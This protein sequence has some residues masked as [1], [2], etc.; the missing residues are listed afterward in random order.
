M[1]ERDV[2]DNALLIADPA[3][4]R[5]YIATVCGS[6]EAL[7]RRVEI[8]VHAHDGA[9]L[10]LEQPIFP[11]PEHVDPTRAGGAMTEQMK[12]SGAWPDGV[13]DEDEEDALDFLEP[14][15]KPGSL[16]RLSHYEVLEIL[17][18]GGFGTVVKAFDE[19]LHRMVA[20]KIMARG[21]AA[22]SPARKRFLREARAAAAIRHENVV[23]IYAVDEQPI[24]YLVM[25]YIAGQTLQD[26]LDRVGPIE[27]PEVL[28]I[29]LQIADG[30][31]AAHRQG[32]IHRDIK[33]ANIL[34]ED[35]VERVKITDFGLARTVDD[36]SLTQSGTIAGTPLYMAPE[37]A[38]GATIDQRAD[39]FSLGSVLYVMCT[40]R[41]P[42]RA[43]S[44]LAV[45]RRVAEDAARPVHE[46][47]PEVPAG[48]C[49]IIDRLHAKE[50]ADR[51]ASAAEVADLL[52][53]ELESP[54]S[55]R[56]TNPV[57]TPPRPGPRLQPTA[58]DSE[59]APQPSRTHKGHQ[60]QGRPTSPLAPAWVLVLAV[61]AVLFVTEITGVSNF[62]GAISRFVAPR[63]TLTVRAND[64][65]LEVVVIGQGTVSNGPVGQGVW[66]FALRPGQ[67]QVLIR[68][69]SERLLHQETVTIT[70]N[71][72]QVV[73]LDP[74][75][76]N[77]ETAIATAPPTSPKTDL[78]PWGHLV[79]PLGGTRATRAGDR[80]TL[81]LPINSPRDLNPERDLNAPRV[82]QTAKGAWVAQVKVL[83]SPRPRFDP[84]AGGHAFHLAGLI[85]W[86]SDREC[87]RFGVSSHSEYNAGKPLVEF[88]AYRDLK[89]SAQETHDAGDGPTYLQVECRGGM[90][91]LRTS[92]D[93][94]N[95][96]FFKDYVLG[97]QAT[98]IQ[99]GV[100]AINSG[101]AGYAPEFEGWSLRALDPVT[102]T[103]LGS[104]G[105]FE[106]PTGKCR[107][108]KSEAG[109][110]ITI[111]AEL[112]CDI[113]PRPGFSLDAPRVLGDAEGNFAVQ[114]HVLPFE[115]P[116]DT[117]GVVYRWAGLV[118]WA[119]EHHFVRFGLAEFPG[120]KDSRPFTDLEAFRSP[121]Q[122]EDD[123]R[124]AAAPPSHFRAERQGDRLV[125][126]TST[127]GQ[128]WTYYKAIALTGY[129][130]KL[131]VGVAAIKSGAKPFAP[132]FEGW[133]RESGDPVFITDL[134]PWG[135]LVDPLGG[136]QATREGNRLTIAMPEGSSRDLNPSSDP[137]KNLHAPRVLAPVS[138]DFT[139]QFDL[140]VYPKAKLDAF[141]TPEGHAYQFA[142][143]LLWWSER[144][145]LRFGVSRNLHS[146]L[147]APFLD[148]EFFRDR[149]DVEGD[150]RGFEAQPTHFQAKRRGN[151]LTLR[152]SVDGQFWTVYKVCDLAGLAS[153]VYLGVTAVNT[154]YA[155]FTPQFEN[156]SLQTNSPNPPVPAMRT[157]P[158]ASL[159]PWGQFIDI[160]GVNHATREGDRLIMALPENVPNDLNPA[161]GRSLNAPRILQTINGD[162]TAQVQILPFAKPVFDPDS[163]QSGHI[164]HFTGLLLWV[165]ERDFLRFGVSRN[166]E[167]EGGQALLNVEFFRK[168]KVIEGGLKWAGDAPLYLQ[169]ERH[170]SRLILKTNSDGRDWNDYTTLDLTGIPAQ[171]SIGVTAVNTGMKAFAPQFAAWSLRPNGPDEF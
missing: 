153:S 43:S 112:G 59:F 87:L 71:E 161:A 95:W 33:P 2:F 9:Q 64:R 102:T 5:A 158:A 167:H 168:G 99:V 67:Y 143:L 125:L 139:F 134:G 76:L 131:R 129:P 151:T 93:G 80:L 44:T 88:K 91:T 30:L 132:R 46:V 77:S 61:F 25:E 124:H 52:R 157:P 165:G 70:A 55:P 16:G 48:L 58:L 144:D 79:D 42:F 108:L 74:N 15:T 11:P 171:V 128:T 163:A 115:E 82:V 147:G 119:D 103:D 38:L 34:L 45:L 27:I 133:K 97:N 14:T 24:P 73:K 69:G 138:G 159:G 154:T 86:V 51:F 62:R 26:K 36:A 54:R 68:Q 75:I 148:L 31:A 107:A 135:R 81:A 4:R 10:W 121:Q 89:P 83:S 101:L 100:M 78:G 23:N 1:T 162:F 127:D 109:L 60:I 117:R 20:I 136:I 65:R 21:L 92:A 122:W 152:T 96:S 98:P 35:V 166:T 6:D 141:A 114:V 19:K 13:D 12:T 142:G 126:Q 111:P 150:N 140:P 104:W 169:A 22:T 120:G 113:N 149:R 123:L 130:S 145:F 66:D 37:Q 106:D 50:P 160:L 39:L 156:G 63:G 116:G 29:G 7:R 110:A 164:Y 118:V 170:G 41:P 57:V 18:R 146:N 72:T 17:G 40:G 90:L 28:R 84:N 105:Q 94:V 53:G 85:V 8:L 32:L 155:A 47:I 56:A 137:I 49:A 3:A